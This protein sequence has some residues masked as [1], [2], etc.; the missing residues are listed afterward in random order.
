VTELRQK[1]PRELCPGYLKWL[2]QQPCACG[3]GSPAPSDAAHLR[4]GS[5][6][7]GKRATGLQEKPSDKW[8]LPLK[9]AHHMAQHAYG[10]E[11]GWWAAHGVPDPFGRSMRY[12]AAY[13][14][15][16]CAKG[17][18]RLTERAAAPRPRKPKTR[19]KPHGRPAGGHGWP[20]KQRKLQGRGFP[21]G[22]RGL[23]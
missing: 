4:A 10:D 20:K 21:K 13:F 6:K 15:E 22:K 17:Q 19:A 16:A 7:Y 18:K 11:V 5:V 9:H 8:A 14:T 23:R 1:Q 2:R 12:Y 3:C